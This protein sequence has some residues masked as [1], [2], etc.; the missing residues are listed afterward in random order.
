MLFLVY[1]YKLQNKQESADAQMMLYMEKCISTVRDSRIFS[2]DVEAEL[3]S[4]QSGQSLEIGVQNEV[5]CKCVICFACGR[6]LPYQKLQYM[7]TKRVFCQE[8]FVRGEKPGTWCGDCKIVPYC[9]KICQ[10]FDSKSVEQG[11]NWLQPGNHSTFCA[12]FAKC[13]QYLVVVWRER[14]TSVIA[15]P[16]FPSDDALEHIQ[17]YHNLFRAE[18]TKYLADVPSKILTRDLRPSQ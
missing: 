18:V 16:S 5:L 9:S 13:H 2:R 6:R 10:A 17:P 7:A 14:G 3:Q 8:E 15:D 12:M 4:G 1:I 11:G